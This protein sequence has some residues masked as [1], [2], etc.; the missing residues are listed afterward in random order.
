MLVS[1]RYGSYGKL[2]NYQVNIY[3]TKNKSAVTS[4]NHD[5]WRK[6]YLHMALAKTQW[7][8]RVGL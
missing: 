4:H 6:A 7:K 1:V 5:I 8:V 3:I 2:K